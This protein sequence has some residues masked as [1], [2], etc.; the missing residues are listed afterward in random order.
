MLHS[1]IAVLTLLLRRTFSA[2]PFS[3]LPLQ[4][5]DSLSK[6][7]ERLVFSQGLKLSP[8]PLNLL[9]KTARLLADAINAANVSFEKLIGIDLPLKLKFL[10]V[11]GQLS[12]S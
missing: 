10:E 2:S 6:I 5:S 4:E 1:W 11:L 9:F 12:R 7:I 3:K 8:Q